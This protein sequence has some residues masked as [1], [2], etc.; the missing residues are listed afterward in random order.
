MFIT[1]RGRGLLVCTNQRFTEAR[2]NSDQNH[3]METRA[4]CLSVV[5]IDHDLLTNYSFNTFYALFRII[6]LIFLFGGF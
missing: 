5:L 2:H 3:K 1:D 6:Y 4:P